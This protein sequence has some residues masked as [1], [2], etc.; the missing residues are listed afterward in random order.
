[1]SRALTP[2]GCRLC[3]DQRPALVE[4]RIRSPTER[5]CIGGTFRSAPL[6][7]RF[8]VAAMKTKRSRPAVKKGGD[9]DPN[10]RRR[11]A[12]FLAGPVPGELQPHY[13]ADSLAERVIAACA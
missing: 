12:E 10:L 13:L 4:G 7:V 6:A 11:A 1:M 9:F 5:A 3:G 2:L 8:P